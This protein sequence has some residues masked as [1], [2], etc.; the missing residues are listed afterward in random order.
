MVKT[1]K[2]KDSK[3]MQDVV[4]TNRTKEQKINDLVQHKTGFLINVEN[5]DPNNSLEIYSSYFNQCQEINNQL[6]FNNN[7][8]IRNVEGKSTAC[9]EG[10][11]S[12]NIN[13]VKIESIEKLN[14]D[15]CAD[16]FDFGVSMTYHIRLFSTVNE[17]W[18]GF[19]D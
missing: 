9:I 7:N 19:M 1:A 4:W 13:T 18:I 8:M 5:N 17:I 15:E 14:E 16:M 12:L 2:R 10:M 3:T 6:S 11:G